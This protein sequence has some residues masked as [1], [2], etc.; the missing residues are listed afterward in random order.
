MYRRVLT[1][2][3]V[4]FCIVFF[5]ES[6]VLDRNSRAYRIQNWRKKI[7]SGRLPNWCAYTQTHTHVDSI[8]KK[9]Q[10]IFGPTWIH[11]HHYCFGLDQ[12]NIAMQNWSNETIRNRYL[13][14]SI[15][16]FDYI[17]KRSDSNFILKPEILAKK[18][19]VLLLVGKSMEAVQAFYEAIELRCEYIPAYTALADY[20]F[21]HN[22]TFQAQ[23]ILERGLKCVPG[24]EVLKNKLAE[25]G[26]TQD[27]RLIGIG[28]GPDR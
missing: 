11:M 15:G 18:G 3:I 13:Q 19:E 28:T 12:I 2:I 24:S 17:L 9:Y 4:A 27:K 26:T 23:R 8:G 20:F 14:L 16:E 10:Q 1:V 5:L 6:Y 7:V 25:V 22:D 21:R